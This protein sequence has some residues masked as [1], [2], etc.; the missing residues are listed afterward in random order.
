MD[1][2]YDAEALRLARQA[3]MAGESVLWA[4]RP[5]RG[6][7]PGWGVAHAVVPLAVIAWTFVSLVVNE[8]YRIN[9]WWQWLVPWVMAAPFVLLLGVELWRRRRLDRAVYAVTDLRVLILAP[10]GTVQDAVGLE[11]A[12]Q[13]RRM[14][15]TV[16]LGGELEAYRLGKG[17]LDGGL[18]RSEM[19]PRLERL[20]DAERVMAVIRAA[21]LKAP[22]AT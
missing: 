21:A 5:G 10:D 22:G 7:A 1:E 17:D 20:A 2:R 9:E 11:R 18:R 12:D 15:R 3:V 6:W 8:P 16:T 13:F 19:L 14:G 4:G